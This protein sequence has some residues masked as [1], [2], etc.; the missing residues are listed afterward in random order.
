MKLS[1]YSLILLIA[2][3]A[4]CKSNPSS[5]NKAG[6][7]ETLSE[8]KTSISIEGKTFDNELDFTSFADKILIGKALYNTSIKY[9]ITFI[10]CVFK[11]PVLAYKNSVDN[12]HN[13]T[14]FWGHV[15]FIECKFMDTVSF[16]ASKFLGQCNFTKS[17]FF[18][19]VN[20]EES[21]FNLNAFF[22]WS[23]FEKQV[24]FQNSFFNQKANFMDTTFSENVSFQ[25][26]IF[27]SDAQFSSSKF[28]K[29]ADFSLTQHRG[30]SFYDFSEFFGT[31]DLSH[32]SFSNSFSIN[33]NKHKDILFNNTKFMG[34]TSFIELDF[35]KDLNFDGSFFLLKRPKTN[36]I[37]Q[38]N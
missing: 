26:S 9:D 6:N 21:S 34:K 2:M 22:N 32:S 28:Y 25:S 20:F 23:S 33:N 24:R 3:T 18:S 19:T 5:S 1:K 4:S 37:A 16:R 38:E 14:S 10:N 12:A 35:S 36:S 17:E 7:F 29:Y 8:N 31:L 13:I 15:S 11:K 27:N 30:N